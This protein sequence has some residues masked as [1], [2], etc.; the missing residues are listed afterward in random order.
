MPL[1]PCRYDPSV[2]TDFGLGMLY[3]SPA[4]DVPISTLFA[5]VDRLH[6]EGNPHSGLDGA[7]WFGVPLRPLLPC[8]VLAKGYDE[9]NGHW[10]TVDYGDGYTSFFCHMQAASP[11]E[12]GDSL[13]GDDVLGPVGDTGYAEGPHMHWTL[14]FHGVKVD[15]LLHLEAPAAA[16]E[17]PYT[18]LQRA[19]DYQSGM[20][21]R[22][23]R[24]AGAK[25][26]KV[27]MEADVDAVDDAGLA[28]LS[29]FNAIP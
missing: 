1:F 16:V 8:S 28:I 15:P 10:I 19:A 13:A 9:R 24:M 12:V 29:A 22:L 21:G 17:D 14:N 7:A 3:N 23:G 11:W 5:V 6:P 26:P 18:V 27:V 2:P 4:G 20:L 25:V